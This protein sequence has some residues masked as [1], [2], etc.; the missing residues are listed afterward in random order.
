MDDCSALPFDSDFVVVDIETT[1]IDKH[2][3]RII[4]IAAV[5]VVGGQIVDRFES[6]VNPVIPVPEKI[7]KLT[8]I[9]TDMVMDAPPCD[10]V[11]K[12]FEEFSRGCVFVAHNASFDV[13][14]LTEH[15]KGCGVAFFEPLCRYAD[16]RALFAALFKTPQVRRF[17]RVLQRLARYPPP[18]HVRHRRNGRDLFK[19]RRALPRGGGGGAARHHAPPRC[20][21]TFQAPAEPH[22][23]FGQRRRRAQKIS[24]SWSLTPTSTTSTGARDGPA[25]PAA[26]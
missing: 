19:A 7:T 15:G 12:H 8:G 20:R 25:F 18:R 4:E 6:F 13:G 24:T 3:D 11:L 1:G 14:F 10:E 16:A 26:F 17:N 22:H 21:K 5:K 23:F 2:L 9:T